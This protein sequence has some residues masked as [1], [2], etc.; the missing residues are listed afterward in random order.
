MF[1]ALANAGLDNDFPDKGYVTGHLIKSGRKQ[2]RRSSLST[3]TKHCTVD[4]VIVIATKITICVS[5]YKIDL[6][7]YMRTTVYFNVLMYVSFYSKVCHCVFVRN[8]KRSKLLLI[9]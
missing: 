7:L 3:D 1:L 2:T 8:R 5:S 6:L 9:S 4:E